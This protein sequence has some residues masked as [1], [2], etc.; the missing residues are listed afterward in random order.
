MKRGRHTHRHCSKKILHYDSKFVVGLIKHF[1]S[2]YLELADNKTI[3][4]VYIL[5]L[6]RREKE[7]SKR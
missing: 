1:D 6:R 4:K 3:I 2:T 7:S 5:R